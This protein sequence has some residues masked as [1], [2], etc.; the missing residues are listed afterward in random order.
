MRSSLAS[1]GEGG[2][3]PWMSTFPKGANSKAEGFPGE[4]VRQ[5]KDMEEQEAGHFGI[6]KA[7][8]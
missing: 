5:Q 3:F 8:T 1:T 7:N 4:Q 2:A 6:S